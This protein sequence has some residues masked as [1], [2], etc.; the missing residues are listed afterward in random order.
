M[1]Q[2]FW[3]KQASFGAALLCIFL[4][5]LLFFFPGLTGTVVCWILAGAALISALVQLF[6]YFRGRRSGMPGTGNLIGTVLF[7]ILGIFLALTPGFIL[8]FLPL[9]LGILLII[10]GIGKLP[11]LFSAFRKGFPFRFSLLLSAALSLI[12]GF[13]IVANPFGAAETVIMV[14]GLTLI[15]DGVCDLISAVL[16]RKLR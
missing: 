12:L 9:I 6:F 10:D 1:L 14:F 3:Q 8:G 13:V 4:G 11:L 2:F 5:L 16:S 7:L 15:A